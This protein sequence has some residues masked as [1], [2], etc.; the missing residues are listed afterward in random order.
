M[1]CPLWIAC[2]RGGEG[3]KTAA[4][5]QGRRFAAAIG[6]TPE[7]NPPIQ[8]RMVI[9]GGGASSVGRSSTP[10]GRKF[11]RILSPRPVRW[12]CPAASATQDRCEAS[13][14]AGRATR[15]S[16]ETE[17]LRLGHD[18]DAQHLIDG[19]VVKHHCRRVASDGHEPTRKYVRNIPLA[20]H[21]KSLT[22]S[23]HQPA[24]SVG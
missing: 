4:E 3:A 5:S 18:I 17:P 8:V 13:A 11:H 23:S 19:S 10:D 1:R 24:E 16:A 15:A 21:V 6:S 9:P 2:H 14:K 22:I 20:P 7:Q 12:S